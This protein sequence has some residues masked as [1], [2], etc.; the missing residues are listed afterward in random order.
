MITSKPTLKPDAKKVTHL[1]LLCFHL[2]Q[3]SFIMSQVNVHIWSVP[4]TGSTVMSKSFACRSDSYNLVEPF[5]SEKNQSAARLLDVVPRR[6]DYLAVKQLLDQK[7]EGKSLVVSKEHAFV[8]QP[9]IRLQEFGSL[10]MD[11]PKHIILFRHPLRAMKSYQFI[12][13]SAQPSHTVPA[14]LRHEEVSFLPLK[15]VFEHTYPNN[16]VVDFEDVVQ[17]P[18]K[19]FSRLCEMLEIPDE[20]ERMAS[21][22]GRQTT[23]DQIIQ[24]PDNEIWFQTLR[25]SSGFDR[26]VLN[27]RDHIQLPNQMLKIVEENFQVFDFLSLYKLQC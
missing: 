18:R 10:I 13:S 14:E 27:Q 26:S 25:N 16:I 12:L 22:E 20:S 1:S 4:K 6:P 2:A 3:L 15:Q 7:H 19:Y 9:W 21:W 23:V 24:E 17:D 8:Y 5:L 11:E